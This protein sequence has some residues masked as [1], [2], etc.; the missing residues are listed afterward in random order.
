M[1][2]GCTRHETRRGCVNGG[3]NLHVAVAVAVK[4]HDDDHDHDH[5]YN[6]QREPQG[7]SAT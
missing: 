6:A 7:E 2:R 4:V 3:V 1:S 5:D